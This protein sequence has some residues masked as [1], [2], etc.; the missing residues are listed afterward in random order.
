M[1]PVDIP[2]LATHAVAYLLYAQRLLLFLLSKDSGLGLCPYK[3]NSSQSPKRKIK[4]CQ[5]KAPSTLRTDDE[6]PRPGDLNVA[7]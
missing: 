5:I 1:C 7:Q 2:L 4:R 3:H 6:D